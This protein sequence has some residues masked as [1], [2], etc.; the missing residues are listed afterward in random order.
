VSAKLFETDILFLQR[1]L[2]VADLYG[3]PLDG[4]W[5]S[6]VEAGETAFYAAYDTIKGRLG[7]FD[8][9]TE[10]NI[11]SLIPA[12]QSKAREFMN[13]AAGQPLTYR[14]LSGSRTYAEQDAL[15]AI[16]RTVEL[17][18]KPVTKAKGGQSNHNFGIAWDVGIFNGTDYYEGNTA[19]EDKAYDDLGALVIA[20]VPDLEWGGQWKTFVDKPHYQLATG[21]STGQVRS[22]FEAGT[23]FA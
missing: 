2:A 14:I 11:I 3:G 20:A 9:R 6:D 1:I 8:A 23:A 5:N 13:A 18:R 12:A 7:A 10:R 15:Y 17:H 22:L 21:K 19:Q 16:G 4:K